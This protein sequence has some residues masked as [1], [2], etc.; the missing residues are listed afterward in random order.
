MG[1]MKT[2]TKIF[3]I[4]LVL[5]GFF[6]FITF[7]HTVAYNGTPGF[8]AD[9]K[10]AVFSEETGFP[11]ITETG[12][13]MM[14]IR[15]CLNAIGCE[16]VWDGDTQTVI[17]RKGDT[18]VDIPVGKMELYVNHEA[19]DARAAAVLTNGRTYLPLRDVLE[20]Y[21]YQ[22]EWDSQ[23]RIVTALSAKEKELTPYNINGGTTGIF[24]RKQLDFNGFQGIQADVTLPKVTLAEKGDCPYVYFGF[25]WANDTGNAEGGFQFIE[26]PN[27]PGY[28]RWTVFLRQ[29]SEWRWGENI[30][31]EQGSTHHLKFFTERISEGQTDLVIELDGMEV[32]RKPSTVNDFSKTSVKAVIAMA[33]SKPFDGANCY[34]RS[35]GARIAEIKVSKSG[36]DQYS[37]FGNYKLYSL[38]RPEVGTFGMLYGTADCIPSYLHTA[39]GG[40][41]SIY[42]SK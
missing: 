42:K 12:R 5:I 22:V 1:K 19:V 28:S 10:A 35:E 4:P 8:V 25:D 3:I 13:T 9:G 38:W 33:M 21:G 15:V 31:L 23:T 30:A 27:H 11:Y 40:Y 29:G 26:D 2:T 6:F 16:V 41:L 20:A 34:S 37:D 24:S 17:T 36:S 32:V 7:D 39:D 14:P 18:E